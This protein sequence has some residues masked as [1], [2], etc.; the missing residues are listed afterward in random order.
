MRIK[1]LRPFKTSLALTTPLA[2][3]I[4]LISPFIVASPL[5]AET[6][7]TSEK[8]SNPKTWQATKNKDH[9]LIGKIWSSKKAGYIRPDELADDLL[10]KPHILLGE[11]HDNP[12]HHS[13]QAKIIAALST[14]SIKPAL[15]MEMIKL[16]Q[17]QRLNAYRATK[18]ASAEHLGTAL[19]WNRQGWPDW[20]IYQPIGEQIFKHN[21][22]VF[23]GHTSRTMI[24]HLIKSDMSILPDEARKTFRLDKPLSPPLAEAL[25]DDIRIGHCNKLP[26][27]VIPPMANVQ[28]FRD[29]WMADVMI[30]AAIVEPS[31]SETK[32]STEN[33]NQAGKNKTN[34]KRQVILIAGSG[35]TRT[36]RGAPWYLRQRLGPG[37]SLTVEFIEATSA[38]KKI[39]DLASKTPTGEIAVD[40]VWV[41]PATDREDPCKNIPDF[42]KNK[43]E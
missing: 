24:N 20:K 31:E 37:N 30:Q 26:E 1:F 43:T 6:S 28:R 25:K 15:V 3:F 42:G 8:L 11:I 4:A 40:Y 39:S 23:P 19:Q 18:N 2:L 21:L 16:N 5:K 9:P 35:H 36:D 13:L 7:L 38:A 17:M 27:H 10:T 33:K 41:T 14:K 22:E 32:G 29:A 34:I 12:D